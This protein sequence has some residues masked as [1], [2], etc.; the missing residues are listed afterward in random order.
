M[1][2]FLALDVGNSHITLGLHDGHAWRAHWRWSTQPTATADEYGLRL[3]LTLAQ[4][5]MAP[6]H[7]R[8]VGMVSVVP[9]LIPVLEQA[10]EAYLNLPVW[11]LTSTTEVGLRF[12][13][14]RQQLGLDR[15]A[16]AV[17]AYHQVGG[18]V[19]VVD[20]GT[21]VTV[22][23]VSSEGTFLGGIIAP[24]PGLLAEA[25]ATRTALLP[26]IPLESVEDPNQ[27]PWL[28]RSTQEAL[29][30]GLVLGFLSMVQGLI[31]RV[32]NALEQH[33]VQ[34]HGSPLV[35]PRAIATGGWSERFAAW[36]GLPWFP[37]LTLEGVRLLWLRH[38]QA[39]GEHE[40]EPRQSNPAPSTDLNQDPTQ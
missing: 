30:T 17:A 2:L 7:L 18:P 31:R 13:Y 27:L 4:W 32:C 22:D 37:Y 21:A 8:G 39:H 23:A 33:E 11:T 29:Q 24:G 28:P 1:S 35:S 5:G 40:P 9:Q 34:Q 15:V 38:G 10:V 20:I 25:L 6:H 3:R 26:R 14:N 16:N 12:A 36:L 19:C